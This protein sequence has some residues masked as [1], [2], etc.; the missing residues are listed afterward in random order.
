MTWPKCD[1]QYAPIRQNSIHLDDKHYGQDD[2]FGLWEARFQISDV[3]RYENGLAR[4][5][6]IN[7][8]K[9]CRFDLEINGSSLCGSSLNFVLYIL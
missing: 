3:D 5:T 4:K 1:K 7:L 9:R 6:F 2:V 8:K